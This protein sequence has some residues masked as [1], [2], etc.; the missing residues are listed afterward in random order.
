[1]K[2]LMV[3]IILFLVVPLSAQNH[4]AGAWDVTHVIGCA[5]GD[6]YIQKVFKLNYLEASCVMF[7]F[8]FMW[9][10]CDELYKNGIIRGDLNSYFD[11]HG[12]SRGDIV[13]NLGG[14]LLA[15][16]IRIKHKNWTI[17]FKFKI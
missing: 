13:R 12:F 6:T 4:T 2:K 7:A 14:I 15:Y 5:L 8:G 17:N 16:P 3:L 10:G 11:K 1:M 9:E